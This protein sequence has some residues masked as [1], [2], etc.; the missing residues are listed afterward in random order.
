MESDT[1]YRDFVVNISVQI[2]WGFQGENIANQMIT[3]QYPHNFT[4]K[5]P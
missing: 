4:I 1:F 3:R 5:S 2:V